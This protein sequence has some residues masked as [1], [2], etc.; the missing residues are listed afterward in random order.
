MELL[1]KELTS[2]VIGIYYKVFNTL[3]YG[4]LEKFMKMQSALNFVNQV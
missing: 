4:F 2:Q 3:G 1:H